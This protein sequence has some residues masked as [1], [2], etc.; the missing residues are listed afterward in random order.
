MFECPSFRQVS[1]LQGASGFSFLGFCI[2]ACHEREYVRHEEGRSLASARANLNLRFG[3]TVCAWDKRLKNDRS[4]CAY[5]PHRPPPTRRADC[6]LLRGG[7]LFPLCRRLVL[8]R[9][10]QGFRARRSGKSKRPA[11]P[12][13]TE[14]NK[15]HRNR[16]L[17]RASQMML[18]QR[19]TNGFLNPAMGPETRSPSL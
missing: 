9:A 1:R 4:P 10:V 16:L 2:L 12:E 7:G 8:V 11:N 6:S 3:R 13:A 14:A 17:S 15:R 5:A 18:N 19:S